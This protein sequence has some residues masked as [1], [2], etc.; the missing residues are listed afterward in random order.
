MLASHNAKARSAFIAA[1]IAALLTAFSPGENSGDT[2][3][4]F[5]VARRWPRSTG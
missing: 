5:S 3:L 4:I 2:I 1:T